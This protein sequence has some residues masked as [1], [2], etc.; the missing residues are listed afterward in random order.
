MAGEVMAPVLDTHVLLWWTLDPEMLSPRAQ[1]VCAEI[2][3]TG[4]VVSSISI[5]ELGIKIK[6]GKLDIGL[7]IEE[8]LQRLRRLSSLSI[9][10][11]DAATW[12]WNL[13]LDWGND[14]PADRT[15]VATALMRDAELVSKDRDIRA[16]Y[17][18]TIW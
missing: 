7:T 9:V 16:F 5:W 17:A 2:G 12:V 8:Y 3:R 13:S 4:A 1:E 14:D 11:V 10:P 6:R 18:R 15:I